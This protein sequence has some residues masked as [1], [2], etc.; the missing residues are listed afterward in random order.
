MSEGVKNFDTPPDHATSS[1]Y[2]N[3]TVTPK[4]SHVVQRTPPDTAQLVYPDLNPNMATHPVI[5]MYQKVKDTGCPNYKK[6]KISLQSGLN[7]DVWKR[8][9][10]N[11]PQ[12]TDLLLYLQYGFPLKYESSDPPTTELLNHASALKYPE[13]VQKHIDTEI[14]HSALVGPFDELPFTPWCHSSPLITREKKGS[15]NRCIIT[16]MS[17]PLGHSV[18]ASI[19]R[20]SYQGQPAKT[21]PPS[22]I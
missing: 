6:A 15:E 19:P 10:G 3:H 2:A 7:I 22:R 14:K 13:H 9:L 4:G 8:Y 1:P 17:W 16:D 5:G 12:F 18:N 11:D 20:E 21:V